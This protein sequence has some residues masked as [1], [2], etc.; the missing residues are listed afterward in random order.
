VDNSIAGDR[1]YTTDHET[2]RRWVAERGGL[3]AMVRRV[4]QP[5]E[6]ELVINFANDGSDEPIIDISWA[7]F[8]QRFDD[9]KLAFVYSDTASGAEGSRFWQMVARDEIDQRAHGQ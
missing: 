7:D 2:I 3:P 9:S 1:R 4:G 6:G 8:F 5:D